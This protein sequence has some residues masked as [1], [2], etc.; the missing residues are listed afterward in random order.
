MREHTD[1]SIIICTRN[2]STALRRTLLALAAMNVPP[3]VSHEVIVVDNASSDETKAVI[4]A[5]GATLPVRYLHEGRPGL[6]RARNA[7]LAQAA[8]RLIFMTDDDCVV[9]PDWLEAGLRLIA[10]NPRQV[11]G[12][13]VDLHDTRDLPI[14]IKTEGAAASLD[15]I[16]PLFGFL[17]GCNMIFGRLVVDAIGPFDPLLGAGTKCRGAEDTDFVYRALKAGVAVRYCPD[18]RI[19]HDHGRRDPADGQRLEQGYRVSIGALTLKHLL[20]G[21]LDLAKLL[22]WRMR[23]AYRQGYRV[24]ALDYAAGALAYLRSA[25]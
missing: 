23:S 7:G 10:E 3:M 4:Q 22:Y 5:A 12:G 8:G 11:I 21:R 25:A 13:R 15:S 19:A 17:H 18:L 1:V 24:G 16:G 2:R 20:R 9:Q 14:T 6:G